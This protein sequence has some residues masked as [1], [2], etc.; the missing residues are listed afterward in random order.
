MSTTTKHPRLFKLYTSPM[1]S[2]TDMT[3]YVLVYLE[4]GN[5]RDAMRLVEHPA[6]GAARRVHQGLEIG[7]REPLEGED[8]IEA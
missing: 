6:E 4:A 8:V 1:L 5:I 7:W 2:T 3:G